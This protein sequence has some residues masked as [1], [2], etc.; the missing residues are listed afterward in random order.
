M[1][2]LL[3]DI[4]ANVGAYTQARK[5][6]FERCV[7][8]EA[9]PL[10]CEKL[11]ATFQ[12]EIEQSHVIVCNNIVSKEAS[13]TFYVNKADTISTADIEWV[14]QSRF[15]ESYRQWTPINNVA[16]ISIDELIRVY[17]VPSYLKIDVEGYEWNVIQSLTQCLQNTHIAFEWAEEKKAELLLI[18]DWLHNLGYTQFSVQYEDAYN[19]QPIEWLEYQ[20]V[21][22]QLEQELM[23][24]RKSKWGMIHVRK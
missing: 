20:V 17:G 24:Q 22:Q 8:V 6:E 18:L 11:Q 5:H 21:Y 10:L 4:G 1:S 15:S 7:L 13:A 12:A 19:F 16:T 2:S 23:I 14:Q 3:F 9:N